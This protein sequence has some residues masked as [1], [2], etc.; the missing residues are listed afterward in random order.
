MWPCSDSKEAKRCTCVLCGTS[1]GD[2]SQAKRHINDLHAPEYECLQCHTRSHT[3]QAA[4]RHRSRD[5]PNLKCKQNTIQPNYPDRLD[6][7]RCA[8]TNTLFPTWDQYL[9]HYAKLSLDRN[10]VRPIHLFHSLLRL[11]VVTTWVKGLS[12][13]CND[14]KQWVK[15]SWTDDQVH[16]AIVR[17][18][19][20]LRRGDDGILSYLTELYRTGRPKEKLPKGK[21]VHTRTSKDSAQPRQVSAFSTPTLP[22]QQLPPQTPTALSTRALKQR[23]PI[24]RSTFPTHK[25]ADW[26]VLQMTQR[27]TQTDPPGIFGQGYTQNEDCRLPFETSFG[28]HASQ[29]EAYNGG[30]GWYSGPP[31]TRTFAIEQYG[32]PNIEHNN[33]WTFPL[34][35]VNAQSYY[36]SPPSASSAAFLPTAAPNTPFVAEPDE[37]QAD[38]QDNQ[39]LSPHGNGSHF[40]VQYGS[41]QMKFGGNNL[42]PFD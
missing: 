11:D 32:G 10:C 39:K 3:L 2:E 5:H 28:H 27:R 25:P 13:D 8:Y 12:E 16:D 6:T 41:G 35:M 18:L 29:D 24:S 36:S 15:G 17:L 9:T 42:F 4:R 14:P 34:H 37:I 7:R 21:A 22:Q 31:E 20:A 30:E 1:I 38:S 23:M 33:S 26:M 19:Q 40:V